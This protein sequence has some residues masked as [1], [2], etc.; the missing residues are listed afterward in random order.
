MSKDLQHTSST[1]EKAVSQTGENTVTASPN[2]NP[3]DKP[4]NDSNAK[5]EAADPEKGV[6]SS[7]QVD[8]SDLIQGKTLAIVWTAFLM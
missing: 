8:A 7:K 3:Q 4:N 2:L 6:L 5:I 1:N